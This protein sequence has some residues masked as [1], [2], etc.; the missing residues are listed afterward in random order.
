[1]NLKITRVS[2]A[3]M[4]QLQSKLRE[5]C[6]DI[7]ITDHS[8]CE[9]CQGSFGGRRL[10]WLGVGIY[11]FMHS[12]WPDRRKHFETTIWGRAFTT[13][14]LVRFTAPEASSF[15]KA[16]ASCI[17]AFSYHPIELMQTPQK[18]QHNLQ[19]VSA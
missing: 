16:W 19:V 12:S 2:S 10:A 13:M 3:S 17:S 7:V 14:D 9:I 1:M 5:V 8:F 6:V 15:L 11:I 18:A 4:V